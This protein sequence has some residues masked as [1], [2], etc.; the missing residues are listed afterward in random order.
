[1]ALLLASLSF[2]W[3]HSQQLA[4]ESR[5]KA[6]LDDRASEELVG[7]LSGPV[8][9]GLG[10]QKIRLKTD[11]ASIL[12][13]VYG[14]SAQKLLPGQRIR[15]YARLKSLRGVRTLGS[16]SHRLFVMNQGAELA[17][18]ALA[19]D[20]SVVGQSWSLWRWP[21]KVRQWAVAEI[22]R[23]G[24]GEGSA[25]ITALATGQRSK[26]DQGLA[27]SLRVAGL[28]HLLAVSGMHLAAITSLV[29][30]LLL[31]LWVRL[32]WRQFVEP[33]AVAAGGALAAAVVFTA[34]T[35][36]RPSTCRA[37][38][39]AS[40]MLVGIMLDRRIRLI[41]ALA[42]A[43]C[44][45][46]LWRPTLL[47]DPGFQM[48]F[49]AA[50]A[51]ALAF[52]G[53]RRGLRFDN[54][55]W[56]HRL[57]RGAADLLKA[58]FWA[59]LAT[60]PFALHHFGEVSWLGLLS[61]LI[62]VPLTTLFLLPCT[63]L[64]LAMTALGTEVGGYLLDVSQSVAQVL[65]DLCLWVAEVIPPQ[66]APGL[67]LGELVLWAFIALLLL[68]Q[69]QRLS[70]RP[71][72]LGIGIALLVFIGSRAYWM[73]LQAGWATELRV[74]Y[75]DIGQGDA[76]VL[77][78]PGGGVWLIDGGG[79]PFVSP[80]AIGDRERLAE[81][82]ARQFLLP[83]LRHRRI[84][85]IDLA[86]VSHPHPDHYVG[87][88]AVAREIPIAEVWSAVPEGPGQYWGWL[89]E[90][91][92]AGSKVVAPPLGTTRTMGGVGLN[93]LWP[94]Y[95]ASEGD[96]QSDP[97]LSLNDNSLVVRVDFAGR[98]LLFPG[99]IEAEAEALLVERLASE[100]QADVVKVPHHG[101][102]TSSTRAF[103]QAVDPILSVISC[104]RGNRFDFPAQAVEE[105]WRQRGQV[106]LRT[107]QVG[108]VTVRVGPDGSMKVDTMAPF[109]GF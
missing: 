38:L 96:A 40:F 17:A 20:V 100:I 37:L 29:F 15:V 51:L 59:T 57:W 11:T 31:H 99:D 80:N 76:I 21:E 88:R 53:E 26:I 104:G 24:Q 30:L 72:I 84:N 46:L 102:R 52:G 70:R 97:I 13:T 91:E 41:D 78:L 44:L 65:A 12:L 106:V 75:V 39:V 55:G 35:G 64:G 74:T 7:E 60:A 25:L 4:V 58:S 54:R 43:S 5:H 68:P 63:L 66:L 69:S 23:R 8:I 87:L 36:G 27:A 95:Q 107:D 61:N 73:P 3:T 2:L 9:Q 49:A 71:R 82:P 98:R 67:N 79:L 90:L 108:S 42:W 109:S 33:R 18:T 62:A 56:P 77:E 50:V 93:V 101:S 6:Q 81:T 10:N 83:Y 105:R 14:A 45:L 22:G 47:W 92:A 85:Q 19:E 34:I 94:R 103:V 28:S 32:P 89:R 1:M 86:I 16:G 48:S